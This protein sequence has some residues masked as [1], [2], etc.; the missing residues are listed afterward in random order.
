VA[1]QTHTLAIVA[2]VLSLIPF[3]LINIVGLG[4]GVKALSDIKKRPE[5]LGGHGLAL[6]AIII[7]GLW[8]AISVVGI[9]AAIAIPNFIKFQARSKQSEAKIQLRAVHTAA[10]AA[11]ESGE[12]ATT[13]A[14]LHVSAEPRRRYTYFFADD[15]LPSTL[16]GPYSLPD[17]LPEDWRA[18]AV[19]NVDNDATLDVW[20]LAPDGTVT[21]EVNDVTE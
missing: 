21:N 14:A 8:T 18:V 15:V 9:L 16:G 13:F 3:C 17:R 5:E 12:A 10:L 1:R 20:V 11:S 7:G 4:L 2:F 6:A 19:G